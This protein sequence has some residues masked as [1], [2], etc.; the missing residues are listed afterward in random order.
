MGG[1]LLVGEIPCLLV[2]RMAGEQAG[3][4]QGQGGL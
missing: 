1:P 2:D 4:M 3:D